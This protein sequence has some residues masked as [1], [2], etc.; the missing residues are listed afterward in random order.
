MWFLVLL[1]A[2]GADPAGQIAYVHGTEQENQQVCV[3]DAATGQSVPVGPGKGDGAPVWSPDG[4][5]IAYESRTD[6]G[7]GIFV[8]RPDGSETL[9]VKHGSDWNRYPRWSPD[10]TRLAYVSGTG[11]GPGGKCTVYDIQSGQETA[12]GGEQTYVLSAA[13]MPNMKLLYALRPDQEINSESNGGTTL[14]QWLEKGNILVG[15]GLKPEKNFA[16]SVSLISQ[17]MSADL[18]DWVYEDHG[19][20]VEWNATPSPKGEALA[21]ESNDGGD[22]EIYVLTKKGL[23]DVTNHRAADWYPVWSADGNWLAFES[24]RDGRRGIYRVYPDTARISPVAVT[25]DSDNWWPTWSPSGKW[26]AFVSD[27]SGN[28]EIHVTDPAGKSVKQLTTGPGY[29]VAPAWSPKRK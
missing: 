10:G 2:C 6:G 13:W 17:E 19:N 16:T 7:V 12:W 5:W 28:P 20:Y 18:P 22:R 8:S 29:C 21:F 24:F 4:A 1:T 27:R 11:S 26:L 15:I 3:M 9:P 14:L 23:I 25:A